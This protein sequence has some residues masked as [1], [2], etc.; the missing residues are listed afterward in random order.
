MGRI[1]R[2]TVSTTVSSLR[3]D[4]GSR[5]VIKTDADVQI[6]YDIGDFDND[7]YFVIGANEVYV[8]DPN[9]L[10]GEV[11]SLDTLFYVKTASGTAT[12]QVWVQS[13]RYQQ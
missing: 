6:A 8:F 1:S 11:D 9:P 5:V 2:Y 3:L 7:Q 10:T 4:G 13:A 12:V